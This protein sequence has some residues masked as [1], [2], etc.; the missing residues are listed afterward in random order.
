MFQWIKS[1]GRHGVR[2]LRLFV[3]G[4][5]EVSKVVLFCGQTLDKI[6]MNVV[7][8]WVWRRPNWKEITFNDQQDTVLPT[9]IR[10][11]Y[12]D[13]KSYVVISLV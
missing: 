11:L 8:P 5:T 7:Y 9:F 4:L 6:V 13:N 3:G 12:H 1:W 2:D 10:D